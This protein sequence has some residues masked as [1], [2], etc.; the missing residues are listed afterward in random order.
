MNN[1]SLFLAFA[2]SELSLASKA[3]LIQES[4]ETKTRFSVP[5]FPKVDSHREKRNRSLT[6][7][8]IPNRQQIGTRLS[9]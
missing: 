7:I 8:V 9:E 1:E 4:L 6:R 2:G 3:L 5:V